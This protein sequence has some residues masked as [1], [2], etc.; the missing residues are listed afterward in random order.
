[1]SLLNGLLAA[2]GLTHSTQTQ[3]TFLF[4]FGDSY[5]STGYDPASVL[6][7]SYLNPLGNPL[8]PGVTTA[9]GA[10][11]VDKL[12]YDHPPEGY[13]TFT[14]N[15]AYPGALVNHSIYPPDSYLTT[16]DFVSQVDSFQAHG[17]KN[18]LASNVAAIAYWGTNDILVHAEQ[19]NAGDNSIITAALDAYWTKIEQLY[20]ANVRNFVVFT[21]DRQPPRVE[22]PTRRAHCELQAEPRRREGCDGGPRAGVE[23]DLGQPAEVWGAEQ[24]MRQH[25][26]QELPVLRHHSSGAGI[27]HRHRSKRGAGATGHWVLEKL[28]PSQPRRGSSRSNAC[29]GRNDFKR[30]HD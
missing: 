11:W 1:M 3:G 7:P 27:A 5:S 23:R 26:R 12:T 14:Y 29:W 8:Y 9:G 28:S 13:T 2:L 25:G 22:P 20:L 30:S 21:A 18:F 24:W 15:Y 6:Q 10:N 16:T 4:T 19:T 17:P